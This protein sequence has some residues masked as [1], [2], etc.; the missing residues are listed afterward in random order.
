MGECRLK[1]L[2]ALQPLYEQDDLSSRLELFTSRF[3]ARIVEMSL[4]KETDVS[5]AALKLLTCIVTQNDGALE[6]KDCENIYELVYHMNRQI[7]QE[8]G[9]FLNAKLFVK[10]ENPPVEFKRGKKP[11]E[12]SAFIQLLIQF[13]IESEL[14]THPTYLVDAMWDIHSML[15]DWECMTDLLLEDPLN[16]EDVLDDTHERLL[17]RII[18]CCVKQA[19]TGEYPIARRGPTMRRLTVKEN[20]QVQDDR[21]Q[22]TQHFIVTLPALITKY[23]A[24]AEKLIYLLQIPT[25]FDLNQYMARRQEKSLE[26]LLSLIQE[27]ITKHNDSE[28]LGE[29]SKCLAYLCDEDNSVYIKCNLVR[30]TIMDNLV[31]EFTRAM[32]TFDQQN[33]ADEAEMYPLVIAL[34]RLSA[35]A[36]NHNIA[37]YDLVTPSI[38]IIKWVIYNEGFG[39]DF[40]TRALNLTRSIITWNMIKLNTELDERK[41]NNDTT[42]NS[43]M[44]ESTDN[45]GLIDFIAKL[46]KKYYKLCNK[47]FNND[48]A[49]IEEEAYF[50]ICDLLILFNVHSQ[51]HHKEYK[52][53]V[54]ECPTNDI[55][56]LSIYVMNNVFTQEALTYKEDTTETVE[57][58]HKRRCI[59]ASFC[60]LISFNCVPI[61]YAAEIFRG[62][63]KYARSYGDIIKH[64]L[65]TCREISKVNTAKTIVLALEREFNE[66][67]FNAVAN[68]DGDSA[69]NRIDRTSPEFMGLKEL[70]R[71]FC[72]SFGPDQASKSRDAIVTIHNE[73]I[74]YVN[75]TATSKHLQKAPLNLA[76]LE[77]VIEF[78]NRLT[79]NDKRALLAELD[80]A[81]AKR[82]NKIE[83]NGW[84]SYY[85]YRLSLMDDQTT[86]NVPPTTTAAI[87][88]TT[89]PKTPT[90]NGVT[91]QKPSDI[92]GITQLRDS[93]NDQDEEEDDEDSENKQLNGDTNTMASSVSHNLDNLRLSIIKSKDQN[94]NDLTTR[95]TS[96]KTNENTK[97]TTSKRSRSPLMSNNSI[98]ESFDNQ[99]NSILSSTRIMEPIKKGTNGKQ[100]MAPP[101]PPIMSKTTNKSSITITTLSS[102]NNKDDSDDNDDDE[103]DKVRTPIPKRSRR[104]DEDIIDKTTPNKSTNLRSSSRNIS[105]S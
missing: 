33:E 34:K 95:A 44:D 30:S 81:F 41:N 13:L 11:S 17:V 62:Y 82:A 16:P 64:L 90:T 80:K 60:K 28:V 78:S 76:F 46:S 91:K 24:D 12:N 19:A 98:N 39:V 35:F 3:K 69:N 9:Q 92:S 26:K 59:L 10:V 88:T 49:Q 36:E 93:F 70:T 96:N 66:A 57:Q 8:A 61:K 37:N 84:A 74:R 89:E 31:D 101:L 42:T 21:V 102:N 45:T 87:T 54:I 53:L 83:E 56:M 79:Q 100:S 99:P 85:T 15:K 25:Y 65:A 97:T 63:I 104:S 51:T 38:T 5:V 7:A 2:Q 6:D 52:K 43:T 68:N 27:I 103:D 14:N 32:N 58:T 77:I 67:V 48:N 105:V 23:I 75:D 73:A 94:G 1:C 86:T 50:E 72:L 18:A 20:K 71:R 47:L 55:N 40:V 29:C 4:D 22:L